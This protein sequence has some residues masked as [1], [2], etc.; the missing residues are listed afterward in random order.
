MARPPTAVTN[1]VPRREHVSTGRVLLEGLAA[2]FLLTVGLLAMEAFMP[3]FTSTTPVVEDLVQRSFPRFAFSISYPTG[4]EVK[5]SARGVSVDSG[6][7]LGGTSTRGFT[8]TPLEAD[9][10]EIKHESKQLDRRR[11]IAPEL[12]DTGR[13]TR[14]GADAYKRVLRAEGLRIQQ[15][16]ID[17]GDDVLRL[18]FWSRLADEDA[19][20]IDS[21]IVDTLDLH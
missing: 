10:S 13:G 1:P 4:W 19:P 3:K 9:F 5:E 11:F 18:E 2:A 17:R 6:E 8:V 20:V 7:T 12:I 16:W 14:A 15:W 21:R